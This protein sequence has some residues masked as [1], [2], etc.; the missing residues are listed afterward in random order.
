[1]NGPA[2]EFN[3]APTRSTA[4]PT[5]G[6]MRSFP[7]LALVQLATYLAAL[8]ACIDGRALYTRLDQAASQP[9]IAVSMVLGAACLVGLVG[10]IIGASQLQLNRSALVGGAVGALYGIVI[11]AVYAAPAPLERAA[12]AAALTVLTTI[13]FRIRAA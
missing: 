8:T 11:L 10:V 12:A 2:S 1:V 5:A 6:K 7:L 4:Q 9:I 13:A 3:A